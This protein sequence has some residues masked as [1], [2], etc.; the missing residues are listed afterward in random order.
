MKMHCMSS[1]SCGRKDDILMK[2]PLGFGFYKSREQRNPEK[3][4]IL[5][6]LPVGFGLKI[7]SPFLTTY[8][9]FSGEAHFLLLTSL[10]VL[11][12]LQPDRADKSKQASVLVFSKKKR[13]G[14]ANFRK[15]KYINWARHVLNK[16]ISM[17][18]TGQCPRTARS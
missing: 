12:D 15:K 13:T 5:M 14:L 2:L 8:S 3:N 17:G 10:L 1:L 18:Q 6:Q 9:P 7:Q 16:S 4:D 11:K